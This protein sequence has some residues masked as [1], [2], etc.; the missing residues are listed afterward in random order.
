MDIVFD[1]PKIQVKI[2]NREP[3]VHKFKGLNLSN[4]TV[5]WRSTTKGCSCTHVDCP[6]IIGPQQSF[7]VTMI[8][9][10]VGQ[11]GLFS[12]GSILEFDNEDKIKLNINGQLYE[13]ESE[14]F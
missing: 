1:Q 11:T 12:V 3:Y 6:L 13:H 14:S 2:S 9:D 8:I 5:N 7:E 10:K 4:K